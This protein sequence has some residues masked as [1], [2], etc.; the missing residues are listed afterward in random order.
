MSF[1]R[2]WPCRR[3]SAAGYKAAEKRTSE[4]RVNSR[5]AGACGFTWKSSIHRDIP[6]KPGYFPSFPQVYQTLVDRRNTSKRFRGSILSAIPLYLPAPFLWKI[7]RKSL[8]GHESRAF[9]RARA[10]L[11]LSRRGQLTSRSPA[12]RVLATKISTSFL[13]MDCFCSLFLL[14]LFINGT[15]HSIYARVTIVHGWRTWDEGTWN[16]SVQ[17]SQKKE[18]RKKIRRKNFYMIKINLIL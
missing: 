15:G 17:G 12:V 4:Q 11:R 10:N 3:P 7:H 5:G 6:S 2:R 16:R 14:L 8:N 18:K 13:M 9:R 1:P